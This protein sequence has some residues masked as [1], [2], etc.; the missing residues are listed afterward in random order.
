[1]SREKEYASSVASLREELGALRLR[2]GISDQFVD[3][4]RRLARCAG[5]ITKDVPS[6]ANLC[7][8]LVSTDFEMP[9]EF[10]ASMPEELR[11]YPRIMAAASET[12]FRSR[13]D[14]A[15]EILNTLTIALRQTGR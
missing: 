6:C 15:D 7:T 10:T 9:P 8:E 13:C 1:M 5:A 3:W 11:D 12:F 14:E 2:G 4:H